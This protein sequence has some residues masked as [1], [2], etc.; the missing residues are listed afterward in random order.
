MDST[1]EPL[2][3][4]AMSAPYG[5]EMA[6][7]ELLKE[8]EDIETFVPLKRNER[9]V[10]Q[11]LRRRMI[12]YRPVVRNLLFIKARKTKM[13]LLK[14]QYNAQLQFKVQPDE[15][16]YKPIIVPDKQMADFMSLYKNVPEEE[17]EYF[18]PGEIEFRP[19]AKVIIEDGPFAGMEGY[20]QQVKGRRAKRFIVRIEG[21][22]SCAAFLANCRYLSKPEKRK[23]RGNR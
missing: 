5:R 7:K 9:M 20:Y 13:R 2:Q 8:V 10:G 23:K 12:S 6:I 18:L 21:F 17:R 15:G 16:K 4:Y 14:Q 22:L 19:E 3:W 11:K 1:Q